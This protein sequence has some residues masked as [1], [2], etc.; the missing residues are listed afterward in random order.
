MKRMSNILAI[1]FLASAI[2]RAG[3][4]NVTPANVR[5][6][7]VAG[8][9]GSTFN[10]APGNYVGNANPNGFSFDW[11][12]VPGTYVG[13]GANFSVNGVANSLI[14]FSGNVEISG[15][16]F[17]GTQVL[18]Q[19]GT[20]N[21]HDNTFTGGDLGLAILGDTNSKFVNNTFTNET[22]GGI[23]CTPGSGN[24]YS[25][26]TFDN[27]REPIHLASAAA[28]NITISG[29]KI[30]RASRY[31]IEVQIAAN[32]LTVSN[33]DIRQWLANGDQGTGT[34]RTGVSIACSGTNISITDNQII[35]DHYP[36]SA[37]YGPI[38]SAIEIM[39]D[40]NITI[41]GNTMY[42]WGGPYLTGVHKG[43]VFTIKNNTIY[44][45]A[46]DPNGHD[47]VDYPVLTPYL[48]PT[49]QVLPLSAYQPPTTAPTTA[50]SSALPAQTPPDA[51]A[52]S[53]PPAVTHTIS[54]SIDGTPV[55]QKQVLS[56]GSLK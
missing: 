46:G 36:G 43:A 49:D 38:G 54:V 27:S 48:N 14:K 35:Q 31:A 17:T 16:T 28:A 30:T 45:P 7:V 37:I 3:T 33:N 12:S 9:A 8:N 51:A 13:N 55:L 20:F 2:C 26:N 10:F 47:P 44:G 53:T 40:N 39:G 22:G 19:S 50:P 25:N 41:S 56:D 52:A 32:G 1:T 5:F 24:T 18:C 4:I 11:S 15:F 23:G 29:N 34:I 42:N 6:T 21:V